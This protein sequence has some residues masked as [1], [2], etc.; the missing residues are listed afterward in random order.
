MKPYKDPW[1]Y[2]W[3]CPICGEEKH[4]GG[5]GHIESQASGHMRNKH[6]DE[7]LEGEVYNMYKFI[8]LGL[9][10]GK[11]RGSLSNARVPNK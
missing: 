2:V 10:L 9:E 11:N 7:C 5:M 6:P 8:R 1:K 4:A 3:I